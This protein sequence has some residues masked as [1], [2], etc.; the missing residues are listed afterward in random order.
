MSMISLILLEPHAENS[1]YKDAYQSYKEIYNS[2]MVRGKGNLDPK[3]LGGN[4]IQLESDNMGSLFEYNENNNKN[5]YIP[6]YNNYFVSTKANGLRFML[7]I[8]N[9]N[10]VDK[11]RNI[12]LVDSKL[13][14]WVIRQFGIKGTT[15]GL[16]NEIIEDTGY[17]PP[18]PIELNVDKCLIDGELLFWGIIKTKIVGNQ[19]K[20]YII[21][22]DGRNPCMIGFLAFDILYGPT[23]PNYV[24]DMQE[25]LDHLTRFQLGQ[26][27]GMV[28]PKAVGR[29]PTT[30]RRYVLEEMFLNKD[31]PL[32]SYL[33]KPS[34]SSLITM[35]YTKIGGNITNVVGPRYHFTI[36]VSPFIN[37]K[38]LFE[39]R[40]STDIYKYM[41]NV[42]NEEVSKQLYYVDNGN[43]IITPLPGIS[44]NIIGHNM[45]KGLSSD[46][47]IFTPAYEDYLIGSWTFCGNKQY[48]WK[49]S[50]ELTIDFEIG[51]KVD[52]IDNNNMYYYYGLVRKRNKVN[53]E[54]VINNIPYKAIIQSEEYLG[55]SIVECLM[56]YTN[57][58]SK[59]IVFK[60]IQKRY[61]KL[62]PNSYLT[63]YSILNASNIRGELNFLKINKKY[64]PNILDLILF[65][66]NN[67]LNKDNQL[68]ILSTLSKNKLMK[69]YLN[70]HPLLLFNTEKDNILDMIEKRQNNPNYELEIRIDFKN[71]RYNYSNCLIERL[72]ESEYVP[73]PIVKIYDK[74]EKKSSIR[75]V[76]T[77]IGD[78]LE[79]STLLFEETIEKVKID[80][81]N[82]TNDIYNYDF[83]IHLSN[84][85][86]SD[87]EIKYKSPRAGNIEYQIRYMITSLSKY[88]RIDIIE[89]GNSTD[90]NNA[91]LNWKQNRKT[92]IEIEYA[93]ASYIEDLLK[94]D[95]SHIK[96]A[97]KLFE[98]ENRYVSKDVLL[99]KFKKYQYKLN[100][101]KSIIILE[102]LANTLI[103][104][105]NI[106]DMD[107]GNNYGEQ[108]LNIFKED[109]KEG[110][111]ED[112]I[113][114][115]NI[116]NEKGSI[117]SR[118]RKFHN[119]IKSQ[120][121]DEAVNATKFN[122]SKNSISLLDISVGKGGDIYKWNNSNIQVVYGIDP[123]KESIEEA[124]KRYNMAVEKGIIDPSK[125]Y[126][127]EQMTISE[128]NTVINNKYDIVSCQFTLHYFFLNDND[129]TLKRVIKN[130]SN[131]LNIGG[132]FIGTTLVDNEIKKLIENNEFKDKIQIE[133]INKYSYKMKL[134]DIVDIYHKD[135][136][137]YYVNMEKLIK[138]CDK[139]NLKFVQSDLFMNLYQSYKNNP[140]NK[141]NLLKNY[142][143]AVSYLNTTFTFQKI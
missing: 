34:N 95:D 39:G 100:K 47:L 109:K 75:S 101:A 4:P 81:L 125:K 8:G 115:E 40:N 137:E 64:N 90:L 142:E 136:P 24:V 88:W 57:D 3:F 129:V 37:M 27:S 117:F 25:G 123:D 61:D 28:G 119:Y 87:Y 130:V 1:L 20:E 80:S 92:R 69:C 72:L 42:L 118:M 65:I 32:W 35:K 89:F 76:Y 105:F 46:G 51:D 141:K 53:F 23:N 138:I 82:I 6:M 121:I 133:E 126:T 124:K 70:K 78:E 85:I 36:F 31:S 127:F 13:N 48:K 114:K 45:G 33:H 104:L 49:P 79:E 55:N 132:F 16:N 122:T 5:N 30:R 139:Y 112:M 99:S 73:I 67:Q 18:I 12:Y 43:I 106:F 7:M 19:I 14:F 22:N 52:I 26:N 21:T 2:C 15:I 60:V 74:F 10:V 63:A 41:K 140:E 91:K 98:L 54:Y 108:S 120:L 107:V 66:K 29:W 17:L 135:L 131:A 102:D 103:K 94:W 50:D 62:E 96:E 44:K 116:D 134:L 110:M 71:S 143:K 56:I 86:K 84:E 128:P 97:F 113:K 58:I 9:Q 77:L 93:P 68:N 59:Y 83:G 11:S 38:E 111:K